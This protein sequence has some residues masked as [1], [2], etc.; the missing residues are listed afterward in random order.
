MLPYS[1]D[2]T[3]EEME[4]FA[5]MIILHFTNKGSIV[6]EGGAFGLQNSINSLPLQSEMKFFLKNNPRRSDEIWECL[7]KHKKLGKLQKVK[8]LLFQVKTLMGKYGQMFRSQVA[9]YPISHELQK[10]IRKYNNNLF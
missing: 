4:C 1:D 9:T 2:L 10:Q 3:T 5:E 7:K 8:K 6:N